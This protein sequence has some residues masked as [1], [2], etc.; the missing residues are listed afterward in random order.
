MV[1]KYGAPGLDYQ[2]QLNEL[3]ESAPFIKA[4]AAESKGLLAL[5]L[6]LF[7]QI[8][9]VYR[10]VDLVKS[11]MKAADLCDPSYIDAALAS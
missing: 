8:I 11:Q 1:E 3:K 9:D 7:D 6:S 10:K 5:D 4:G 2:A